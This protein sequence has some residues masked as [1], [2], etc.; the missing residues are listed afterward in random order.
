LNPQPLGH[1]PSALTIRSWL[2]A[3]KQQFFLFSFQGNQVAVL[4]E[5]EYRIQGGQIVRE[6]NRVLQVQAQ[7]QAK[8]KAEIQ[9]SYFVALYVIKLTM[10]GTLYIPTSTAVID[11][12]IAII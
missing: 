8:R 3:I 6:P 7:N 4:H 2:L 5:G 12:A 9:V 11:K 10:C 1:E